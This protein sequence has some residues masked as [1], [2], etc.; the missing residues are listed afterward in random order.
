MSIVSVRVDRE[1]KKKMER[2]RDVNWSEV[3]RRA[4]RARLEI[5]ESLRSPIDRARAERAAMEME[6][7]R[8]KTSGR[9]RGAEE[10]RRWRE[11]GKP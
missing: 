7:I 4:I 6:R 3:I 11:E 1:T 9:W 8:A 10:I 5:E 2:Y